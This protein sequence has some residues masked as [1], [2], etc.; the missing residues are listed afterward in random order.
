MKDIIT[1]RGK[2]RKNSVLL[3]WNNWSVWIYNFKM[4]PSSI[5]GKGPGNTDTPVARR[6]TQKPR[7][8]LLR[9]ILHW[10]SPGLLGGVADPKAETGE[11]TRS[12]EQELRQSSKAEWTCQGHSGQ[13]ERVLSQTGSGLSTNWV[14]QEWILAHAIIILKIPESTLVLLLLLIM[15]M[16]LKLEKGRMG[17]KELPY[18]RMPTN[19]CGKNDKNG[20]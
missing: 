18:K 8:S 6:G 3:D 5:R 17:R 20:K 10:K 4:F 13:P 2:E 12:L 11:D 1:G 19:K 9:T 14:C 16:K 15:M 7:S